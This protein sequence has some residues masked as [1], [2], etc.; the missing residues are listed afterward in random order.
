MD[1]HL[2]ELES[3]AF[4]TMSISDVESRIGD[5]E[6]EIRTTNDLLRDILSVLQDR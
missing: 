5:L 6:V 3:I 4:N 2:N 1:K